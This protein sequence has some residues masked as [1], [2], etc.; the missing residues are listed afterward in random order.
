LMPRVYYTKTNIYKITRKL[1]MAYS[2]V[3]EISI[4]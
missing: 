3:T 1:P 4:K 2:T